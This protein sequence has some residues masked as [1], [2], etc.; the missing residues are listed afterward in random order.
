MS[1]HLLYSNHP[2]TS[3]SKIFLVFFSTMNNPQIL[4][5]KTIPF[6]FN[7][8]NQPLSDNLPPILTTT[9]WHFLAS[10]FTV[11]DTNQNQPSPTL[12]PLF[13][14]FFN[15]FSPPTTL[16]TEPPL[17]NLVLLFSLKNLIVPPS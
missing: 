14:T 3:L 7:Q 4:F 12:I 1:L 2:K 10:I 17:A 9:S 5:Y 16:T 15:V 8:D 6:L 13:L 11:K